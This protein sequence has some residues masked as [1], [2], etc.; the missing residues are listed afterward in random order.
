MR[1][2]WGV[3]ISEAGRIFVA[4]GLITYTVIV[5]GAVF[6]E[7]GNLGAKEA[8]VATLLFCAIGVILVSVSF[9]KRGTK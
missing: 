6:G 4:V 8:L 3:V 9:N 2:D 7:Y 1:I 5:A